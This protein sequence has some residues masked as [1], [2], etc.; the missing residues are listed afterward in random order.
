MFRSLVNFISHKRIYCK[1]QFNSAIHHHFHHD[2]HFNQDATTILQAEND[3]ANVVK[4][5]GKNQDKDLGSIIDRLVK[6]E[7]ANRT[8]KLTDFYEQVNQKLT[9]EEIL[10]KKIALELNTI[11]ESNAA[12]YQTLKESSEDNIKAEIEEVHELLNKDK[13]VLGPDGKIMDT[14]DLP[15]FQLDDSPSHECQICK[16]LQISQSRQCPHDHS[17]FQVAENSRQRKRLSFISKPSIYHR[18]MSTNVRHAIRRFWRQALSC[19]ISPMITSKST[20]AQAQWT[21]D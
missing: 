17:G 4:T 8:M 18:P 16:W 21:L 10:Q 12:I 9:Q 14:S 5:S 2:G 13:T 19:D 1:Q 6:R 7:R 3:Y 11:G 15:M 20:R